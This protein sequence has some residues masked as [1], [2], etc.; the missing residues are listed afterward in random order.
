MVGLDRASE[1]HGR[2][3][4]A[5]GVIVMPHGSMGSK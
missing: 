5:V 2:S 3:T 4:A 1:A